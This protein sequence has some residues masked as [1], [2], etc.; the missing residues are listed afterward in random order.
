MDEVPKTNSKMIAWYNRVEHATLEV[1]QFLKVHTLGSLYIL[2]FHF[3][4]H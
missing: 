3:N 2:P 1:L 4:L